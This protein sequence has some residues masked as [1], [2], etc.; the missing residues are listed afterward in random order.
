MASPKVIQ[1]SVSPA[2]GVPKNAVTRARIEV[3]G[4]VGDAQRNLEHHGGPD[5][6]VCLYALELLQMLQQEGHPVFPGA[7]GENLTLSGVN[8]RSLQPGV[9]LKIGAE[10]VLEI[11]RPTPPCKN[12]APWFRDGGFTRVSE[13]LFP[14]QSRLY[15]RV[16]HPG[17]VAVGDGVLILEPVASTG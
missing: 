7:L 11:T 16:L 13:K 1:I 6:A 12:I 4:V 17:A 8:W 15:A 5:R 2:G 3:G 10:V 9:R 14:G